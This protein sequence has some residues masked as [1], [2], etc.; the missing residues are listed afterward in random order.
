MIGCTHIATEMHHRKLRSRGGTD[1]SENILHLCNRCHERITTMQPRTG[2]YRT[3]SWQV[4]GM[5][6]D[7]KWWQP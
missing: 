4:E 7:G 3:H 5:T 6:E 2:K 1:S